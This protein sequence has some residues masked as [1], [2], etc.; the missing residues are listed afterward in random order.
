MYG[1]DHARQAAPAGAG[2]D[3]FEQI[4]RRLRL[5]R[6]ILQPRFALLRFFEHLGTQ[7]AFALV[8][9]EGGL[10]GSR[11]RSIQRIDEQV[12]PFVAPQ[13]PH[14][15]ARVWFALRHLHHLPFST[16]QQPC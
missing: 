4:G 15:L 11:Q 6:Q 3:S 9:V 5:R 1:I 10:V 7:R 2:E 14:W 12:F 13:H 8:P 16:F